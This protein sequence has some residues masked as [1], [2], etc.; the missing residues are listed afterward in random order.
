MPL[1]KQAMCPIRRRG[2]LS[3]NMRSGN[4]LGPISSMLGELWR[5]RKCPLPATAHMDTYRRFPLLRHGG[6]SRR[7]STRAL[8]ACSETGREKNQHRRLSVANLT[9]LYQLQRVRESQRF[10][11]HEFVSLTTA[12][13]SGESGGDE[14]MNPL[15]DK[16][17]RRVERVQR[18]DQSSGT[19]GLFHELPPGAIQG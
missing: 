11:R 2:A 1:Q 3:V 10:E 7:L 9:L 16:A 5:C 4:D 12:L 6:G 19:A 14:S 18:L 8:Q 13:T 17:R 15:V